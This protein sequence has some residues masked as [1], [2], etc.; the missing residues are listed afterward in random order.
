MTYPTPDEFWNADGRGKLR[1]LSAALRNVPESHTW[2][3]GNLLRTTAC[4]TAGCAMGLGQSLWGYKGRTS[5]TVS[6]QRA[7]ERVKKNSGLL[8][9]LPSRYGASSVGDI[10]PLMVADKIDELLGEGEAK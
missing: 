2:D 3:F 7:A 4:G 5:T 9:F 6:L 10:T 1:M 8:F